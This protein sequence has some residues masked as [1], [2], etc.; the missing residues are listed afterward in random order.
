MAKIMGF[1]VVVLCF[2]KKI[3]VNL[4]REYEDVGD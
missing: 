1:F 3:F 4:K 2:L